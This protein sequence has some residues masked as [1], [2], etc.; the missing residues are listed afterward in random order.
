MTSWHFNSLKKKFFLNHFGYLFCHWPILW[1]KKIIIYWHLLILCI[2]LSLFLFIFYPLYLDH[3]DAGLLT[4]VMSYGVGALWLVC[5]RAAAAGGGSAVSGNERLTAD[6]AKPR[7]QT[8]CFWLLSGWN[9]PLLPGRDVRR[10]PAKRSAG[11]RRE[12]EVKAR[13]LSHTPPAWPATTITSSNCWSSVTAVRDSA[14]VWR[15]AGR[16]E[17]LWGFQCFILKLWSPRGCKWTQV[18]FNEQ[19]SVFVSLFCCFMGWSGWSQH[20]PE[21][22]SLICCS[23]VHHLFSPR[24]EEHWFKWPQKVFEVTLNVSECHL[25]THYQRK[26]IYWNALQPKQFT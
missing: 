7:R 23:S 25:I 22:H 8:R 6:T 19:M 15:E 26:V 1:F 9:C 13:G 14:D 2:S 10:L 20:R 21:I 3:L 5:G 16:G 24:T 12:A 17:A 11:E 18:W 4:T